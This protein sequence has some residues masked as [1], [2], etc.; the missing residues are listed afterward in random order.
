M[1]TSWDSLLHL[2]KQR[3]VLEQIKQKADP[4]SG[5]SFMVRRGVA[6]DNEDY[7]DDERRRPWA[8]I[9]TPALALA[10]EAIDMLLQANA[11]SI[12][13]FVASVRRDIDSAT[14]ALKSAEGITEHWKE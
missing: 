1:S 12:R 4:A 9:E 2:I 8:T 11:E 5:V 14:M 3:Q 13:G 10:G 6:R 7:E